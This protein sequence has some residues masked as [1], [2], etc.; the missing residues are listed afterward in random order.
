[1]TDLAGVSPTLASAAGVS[2]TSMASVPNVDLAKKKLLVL[3]VH[4][5]Q[6][7][8]NKSRHRPPQHLHGNIDVLMLTNVQVQGC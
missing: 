7:C 1:L 3:L 5:G 2:S 8:F 6:I 4:N